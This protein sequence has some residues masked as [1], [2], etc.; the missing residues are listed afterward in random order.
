MQKGNYNIYPM[1]TSEATSDAR[2]FEHQEAMR[3]PA[4]FSRRHTIALSVRFRRRGGAE[5]SRRLRGVEP[6][7]YNSSVMMFKIRSA[8]NRTP[9][10]IRRDLFAD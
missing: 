8:M 9:K 6:L 4:R 3:R 5:P 10:A 2:S 1:Q 7:A